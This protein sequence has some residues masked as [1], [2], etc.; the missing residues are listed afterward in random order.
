MTTKST[1]TLTAGVLLPIPTTVSSYGFEDYAGTD[2]AASGVYT[3][4]FESSVDS[5]VAGASTT[6]TRGTVGAVRSGSYS[7]LAKRSIA[8][9]GQVQASRTITGLTVGLSYTLSAWS[10]PQNTFTSTSMT[11]FKVGVTGKGYGSTF[12]PTTYAFAQQSYTFTASATSHEFLLEYTV[13]G[14]P[15]GNAPSA[16][17]DDLTLTRNAY[18]EVTNDGLGGWSSSNGGSVVATAPHTGTYSYTITPALDGGMLAVTLTGISVGRS[19]T[20][21]LW[22]RTGTGTKSFGLGRYGF[23]FTIVSATPTYQ[24]V[25]YTFTAS[26]TSQGLYIEYEAGTYYIDDTTLTA[27]IPTAV[28]LEVVD[29]DVT[30][31]DSHAPYGMANLTVHTPGTEALEALDPRNGYSIT[32][33]ATQTWEEAFKAPQTRTFSLLLAERTINHVDGTVSLTAYTEESK[34]INAGT[35]TPVGYSITSVRSIVSAVLTANGETLAAG[36]DD[37]TLPSLATAVDAT[38]LA[39]NPRAATATTVWSGQNVT[40][41]RITGVT[42]AGEPQLTAAIRATAT[43][44]GIGGPYLQSDTTSPYALITAGKTYSASVWVRASIAKTVQFSFQH[45]GGANVSGPT[46]ALVANTWTKLTHTYVM[47][48]G[49]TRVGPYIYTTTGYAVG[50]TLDA[51]GLIYTESPAPLPYFDGSTTTSGSYS[52]AWTGT[53][54]ASSSQRLKLTDSAPTMMQPGDNYWEFLD[55]LIQAGGLRLFC[56]ETG[57]WRLVDASSYTV[58]GVTF[59]SETQNAVEGSDT[60]SLTASANGVPI[61][62]TGVVI[63]YQW[64]VEGESFTQ[65]DTAGTGVNIATV[66]LERPY[67]GPG[68]AQAYLNR[69]EGRGRVQALTALTDLGATP[70]QQLTST[71]PGTPLQTGV[72]SALTWVYSAEGEDHGLMQVR[73]RAL[74]DT[75]PG[76]WVLAVGTWSAA[77]GTWAAA[78]S[79]N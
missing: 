67:P 61:W 6:V 12:S 16:Y 31:D 3:Q 51:T 63:K 44:T 50:T 39:L 73:S 60:I 54:N 46:T 28:P 49:A 7:I 9:T 35:L 56:D 72:V 15:Y 77:T 19:Y 25:S 23:P 40:I 36:A 41:S 14:L 79:T 17:W 75:P 52:Y 68:A 22:V 43:N 48:A 53:A 26:S 71:M 70:G 11:N 62:A 1:T 34:L 27:P 69:Y 38:N 4:G 13:T 47:P 65:Y 58:P 78:T 55:S 76:A 42:I 8:S 2:Y 24:K 37:F 5:W 64:T 21:A 20:F 30:L 59:V 45:T 10:S 66:T 74:T 57:V 32:V 18:T 33:T 29:G